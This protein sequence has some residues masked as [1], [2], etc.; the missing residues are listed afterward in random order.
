MMS[1]NS[2]DLLAVSQMS[3]A[4]DTSYM[5]SLDSTDLLAVLRDLQALSSAHDDA[6]NNLHK[7]KLI[8][9]KF[10][11]EDAW[12]KL[13]ENCNNEYARATHDLL[14]HLALE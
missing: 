14:V 10:S 5:M 1:L 13:I 12:D 4:N 6:I 9:V 8:L 7:T 11:S 2:S 3:Y